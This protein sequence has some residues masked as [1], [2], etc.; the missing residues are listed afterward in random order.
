MKSKVIT[1]SR[2]FG[3]GGRELG[4]RMADELGYAYYDRE[5][6]TEVAKRMEKDES[7]VSAA[8]EKGVF[9]GIP[10]HYNQTM[11]Y[12]SP[13][14]QDK[15]DLIIETK[16]LLTELAEKGNCIIVGRAAGAFLQEYSPFN[17]FVYADMPYRVQRCMEHAREHETYTE[18]EFEAKIRQIDE[19][20][21]RYY[22]FVSKKSWGD[23]IEY[24]LCVN[25]GGKEIKQLAPLVAA[26]AKA[27]LE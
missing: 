26:Y 6:V 8:F 16:N 14:G 21:S 22:N 9:L 4:K 7:Y 3:S 19:E 11:A 24:H 27:W 2:E 25:T 15:I 1:I 18:R 13:E 5:V 10:V 12:V 23:K 20:R 17:M